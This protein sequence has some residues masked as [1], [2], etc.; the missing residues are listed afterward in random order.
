MGHLKTRPNLSFHTSPQAFIHFVFGSSYLLWFTM[1]RYDVNR[2]RSAVWRWLRRCPEV[3]GPIGDNSG[4]EEF[5][6][7]PTSPLPTAEDEDAGTISG[8]TNLVVAGDA[9]GLLLPAQTRRLRRRHVEVVRQL[10]APC[11]IVPP[12][13]HPPLKAYQLPIRVYRPSWAP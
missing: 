3:I 7:P 10:T 8:E 13:P 1:P 11:P 2:V 6:T 9:Q 5:F 12:R 4:D